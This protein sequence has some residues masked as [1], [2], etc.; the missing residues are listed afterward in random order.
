MRS[1]VYI[2]R[3]TTRENMQ[4]AKHKSGRRLSQVARLFFPS[5]KMNQI[6]LLEIEKEIVREVALGG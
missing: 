5:K 6:P 4:I 2:E 3:D 1:G